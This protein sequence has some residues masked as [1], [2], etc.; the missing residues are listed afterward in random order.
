MA[1]QLSPTPVQKFFDNNGLPAF[2][3]KLYT[4]AAG[5]TTPQAT[6]VDSTQTSQN[7]NPIIL[8]IRGECN[9]WLDPTKTYKFIL[10]D[11]LGN[12]VWSVDNITSFGNTPFSAVDAGSVNNVN[13]TIPGLGT[14]VALNFVTFKAANTN[15]GSVTLTVNGLAKALTWQNLSAFTGGE[16]QA[17]GLYS[18][19]FDGTQWQ[20]QG[21]SLQP[22]QM[23]TTAESTAGVT[24]TQFAYQTIDVTRMGA[25]GDG[26]TDNTTA[27]QNILNVAK[28][29]R[30]RVHFPSQSRNGQTVYVTAPLNVYEG[31]FVTADPDVIIQSSNTNANL[32]IFQCISTYGTGVPLSTNANAAALTVTTASNTGLSANQVV[33]ISDSASLVTGVPNLELNEILSISGVGPYTITLKQALIGSYTTVNSAVITPQTVSARDIHF[34]RVRCNIPSGKD[35]GAFY[36][37][38]AYNCSVRFCESSGQKGQ[39]GVQVWRSAYVKVIGGV[40]RDGQSLSTPGYGYGCSFGQQ[41]MCCFALGVEFRNIRE[42]AVSLG[43][44]WCG[45]IDCVSYSPYD[46]G[47]NAHATGS[48]DCFFI[49]CQTVGAGGPSTKGFY[50]GGSTAADT[51]VQFIDCVAQNVSYFGFWVDTGAVDVHLINPKAINCVLSNA[52]SYPIYIDTVTRPRVVNGYVD[53]N[54]VTNARATMKL[55]ACT[56]AVVHGGTYRG[57]TSGWGIIHANCTGIQI[58]DCLIGNIGSSQG[59]QAEGTPS[60]KVFVRRNKVDNDVVFTKNAGDVHEFNEYNTKRQNNRGA[61]A[62]VAD[63]GT[64]THNCVTTPYAVRATGS[65]AS[66]FVSVTAIGATTFTVAIKTDAGGAGSSQTIYWD[67]DS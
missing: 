33:S 57:A 67:A 32:Q 41:T 56:D 37:Q 11:V 16:I 17:G 3:G 20:L 12:Q 23:R 65:I 1:S 24:P 15:T 45:F 50:C 25:V 61:T 29:G 66:Q 18:A 55:N 19:I 22:P 27:L 43:S 10:Q 21:P 38:D 52:S 8:N 48:F 26:A 49:R 44:R 51:R 59:V 2:N 28:T 36:F 40:Y 30:I 39:P 42:N 7:T 13:L 47:F 62:T 58:D 6:Y 54:G 63:G 4:Y 35:G 9:I 53:A 60:T 14:P 64:I 5:T 31:T 34:E 46:N